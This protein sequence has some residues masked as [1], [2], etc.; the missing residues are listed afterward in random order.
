MA[1]RREAYPGLDDLAAR[2]AAL[3]EHLQQLEARSEGI[4]SGEVQR[5]RSELHQIDREMRIVAGAS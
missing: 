2:R 1:G 3:V 4:A 5:L